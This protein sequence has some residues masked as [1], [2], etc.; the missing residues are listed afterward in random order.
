MPIKTYETTIEING[1]EFVLLV[2]YTAI[3][4]EVELCSTHIKDF[5]GSIEDFPILKVIDR[6]LIEAIEEY[7]RV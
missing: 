5:D 3:E 4:G 6:D 2:G 1:Y 7:E